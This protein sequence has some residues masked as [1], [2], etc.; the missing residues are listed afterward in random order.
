MKDVDESDYHYLLHL[1]GEVSKGDEY[2][3]GADFIK[4]FLSAE[5]LVKLEEGGK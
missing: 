1:F 3:D 2:M 4:Q 5:D